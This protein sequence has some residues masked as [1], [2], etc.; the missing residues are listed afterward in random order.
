MIYR[1]RISHLILICFLLIK[2]GAFAQS[3]YASMRITYNVSHLLDS[4]NEKSR[5]NYPLYVFIGDK[6]ILSESQNKYFADSINEVNKQRAQLNP[7]NIVL[8]VGS[9]SPKRISALESIMTFSNLEKRQFSDVGQ[10]GFARY[11]M[12][13]A[14]ETI[15]WNIK[16][17][18]IVI[19]GKKAQLATCYYKGRNWSAWFSTE[20]PLPYGPWKLNGLPGLI[21]KAVDEKNEVTFEYVSIVK[22]SPKHIIRMDVKSATPATQKQF[23]KVLEAYA[24]N[25]RQFVQN[26]TGINLE[27]YANNNQNS[28]PRIRVP[29]NPIDLS[30]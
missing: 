6:M 3:D 14:M 20:V 1:V 24:E 21:M 16:K 10:I 18:I 22:I 13:E 7:D 25:P 11:L 29:N 23:F 15:S 19:A 5:I 17:D 26:Q 27:P 2:G 12:E 28:V 4:T 9:A 8:N 30:K